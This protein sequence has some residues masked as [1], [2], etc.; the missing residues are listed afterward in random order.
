HQKV[1]RLTPGLTVVFHFDVLLVTINR[2]DLP[3]QKMNVRFGAKNA[4]NGIADFFRF[5]TAGCHLIQQRSK[6]VK[7]VAIYQQ[8]IDGFVFKCTRRVKPAK[9]GT[10][11]DD[12][13][14]PIHSYSLTRL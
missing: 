14:T 2:R 4:T 1:I 11:D 7:V 9:S 8:H 5:K 6:G 13:W 3:H 12:S 10:D